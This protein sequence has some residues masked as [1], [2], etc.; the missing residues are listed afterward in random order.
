MTLEPVPTF[1][2]FE[3]SEKSSS[4]KFLRTGELSKRTGVSTDTL[5]HYERKGLLAPSRSA[6]GYRQYP[7]HAIDRVMLIRNALAIGFKLDDLAR[8][9]KVRE[10][11]GQPCRQ[12]RS[13]AESKLE[14]V[15]TLVREATVMRNELRRLLKDWD[16]RLD[17]AEENQQA[18][19]LETLASTVFANGQGILPLRRLRPKRKQQR[20][21]K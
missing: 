10:A 18:R 16:R 13:L 17:S 11:G 9:F 21:K 19:L 7:A 12:V 5:R 20:E 4:N 15:E 3:V 2:I 1:I 14:E 8:I 6:N